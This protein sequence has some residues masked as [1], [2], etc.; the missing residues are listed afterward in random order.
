MSS[1]LITSLPDVCLLHIFD[2]LPLRDLATISEV[3]DHWATLQQTIFTRRGILTLLIGEQPYNLVNSSYFS[4]PTNS[5]MIV[6]LNGTSKAPLELPSVDES[7]VKSLV[8]K[9]SNCARLE[10]SVNNIDSSLSRHL[11][12]LLEAW[13][14]TLVSLKLWIRFSL[15]DR[16]S[17]TARNIISSDLF[18]IV[19]LINRLPQLTH[20]TLDIHNQL[21]LGIESEELEDDNLDVQI[22]LPCLAQLKEF[23]FYSLN[24]A[25]SLVDSL[26]RYA[27]SNE[28]LVKVGLRNSIYSAEC[29]GKYLEMNSSLLKKF[30]HLNSHQ[31]AK[32]LKN[33]F[34][35]PFCHSNAFHLSRYHLEEFSTKFSSL[36][37]LSTTVAQKSIPFLFKSLSKLSNL[38]DLRLYIYFEDPS[39][40][41]EG[42][43]ANENTNDTDPLLESLTTVKSLSLYGG[44]SSHKQMLILQ[45]GNTFP[46][47]NEIRVAL[48]LYGCPDCDYELIGA[49]SPEKREECYRQMTKPWIQQCPLLKEAYIFNVQIPLSNGLTQTQIY[50]INNNDDL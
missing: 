31:I 8:E 11:C 37:T 49:V 20:L 13:S 2:R 48:S 14:A 26:L 46:S 34:F 3:S 27:Q 32:Y 10:I 38:V 15:T 1:L 39:R 25:D 21:T 7:T 22:E 41:N 50:M 6:E 28:K 9:Y 4:F 36:I 35:L 19:A 5:S 23:Y 47:L 30:T 42:K 24:G 40:S 18:R 29:M 43:S 45:P 16:L 33:A 17:L 12:C 44:I